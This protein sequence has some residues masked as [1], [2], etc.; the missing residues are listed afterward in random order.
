MRYLIT[1]G[2]PDHD[3]TTSQNSTGN[4][5]HRAGFTNV[6]WNMST[7][8]KH[9]NLHRWHAEGD[10]QMITILKLSADVRKIEE[11]LKGN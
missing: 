7:G 8:D 4:S 10:E 3:H 2:Y 11:I 5:L 1:I 9:S 6:R